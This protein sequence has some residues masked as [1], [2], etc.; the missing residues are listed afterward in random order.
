MAVALG[1]CLAAPREW[2]LPINPINPLGLGQWLQTRGNGL[3][4]GPGDPPGGHKCKSELQ[5]GRFVFLCCLLTRRNTL[6]GLQLLS[7]GPSQR[8]LGRVDQ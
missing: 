1:P 7:L 5:L 6:T 3:D 8:F 4:E 2:V